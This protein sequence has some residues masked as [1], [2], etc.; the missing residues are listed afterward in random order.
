MIPSSFVRLGSLPLNSNGKI[1]RA[2]LP[3]PDSTNTIH[4]DSY[5]APQTPTEERVAAIVAPLLGL[6]RVGVSDN[7]FFLGGHS[8]L[9]TQLIGRI[10]DAF[11]VEL[12]L[13]C[14]FDSPTVTQLSTE[15]ERLLL[16]KVQSL[17]EEEAQQMLQSQDQG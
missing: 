2:A 5:V 15:I 10:R 9:G 14:L 17:S 16:A 12:S 4:D 8:L 1:D 11:G 3:L 6:D 7:F 13:R